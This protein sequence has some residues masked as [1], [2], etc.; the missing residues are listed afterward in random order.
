MF[1]LLTEPLVVNKKIYFFCGLP[2]CGNTLLASI[3]NQ[4][5]E[6]TVGANSI[7]PQIFLE[8]RKLYDDEVF[9]NF[10]DTQSLNNIIHNVFPCYY[11]HWKAT[12]ILDRGTWGTKDSLYLLKSLQS[13]LP[14]PLKFII[15][16]RPLLEILASFIRVEK[17]LNIE[18]RCDELMDEDGMIGKAWLSYQNLKKEDSL[19]LTYTELAL[20][21]QKVVDKIYKF[22]DIPL[23]K[24]RFID[25]DQFNINDITYNDTVI[26]GSLHTIR[27]NKIVKLNIDFNSYLPQSIINTYS[28]WKL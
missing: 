16:V 24:H 17:P 25:L 13:Y 28:H 4:N 2:R 11:H 20:N 18:K 14:N 23:F 10:P 27:T 26:G 22:L 5:H 12:H 9:R 15:L 6:I 3:L 21:P 7:L 8:L 1:L 19:I